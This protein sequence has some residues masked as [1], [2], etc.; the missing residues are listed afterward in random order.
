MSGLHSWLLLADG[1]RYQGFWADF[2]TTFWSAALRM[3]EAMVA[4][5]PFLLAGLLAAGMLRGMVGADRMRAALGV[6]HWSGPLRAWALGILL[7]ICSLGALPVARELRRAG[8]PSGTVLSFV[9]VAPVL[10]PVSI[11]Y[12]MS[13]IVP[14]TLVYF[15]IGTF[16]VSVGIGY[17]WNRLIARKQDATVERIES[18]PRTGLGRL[19]VTGHTTVRGL[20][21]PD[22]VD[23]TLA[24]LAVGLLGAFLPHGVLQ[25]GMTR[26]NALAPLLMGLVAI[27]VYVTPVDVMMHFGVIVKDGFSM[28]AAFSL[29]VLG[30]GANVGV[31]NWIRRDYGGKPLLLFV[32]LL[33]GST[34]VLGFTADRA[35]VHGNSTTADHTH[36]F[37]AFTRLHSVAGKSA[38]M[39]WVLETVADQMELYEVYGICL[40]AGLTV[41]GVVVWALGER[42]S[43]DRFLIDAAEASVAKT[44]AAW[45]PALSAR[46]LVAVTVVGVVV[47]A[48]YGLYIFYPPLDDLFNDMSV[49]RVD[50]YDAVRDRD[51][52]ESR[53]R[54]DQWRNMAA[55]L[56]TSR[57]IR[58]GSVSDEQRKQVDELLYSL[59]TLEGY[60]VRRQYTEAALI[61]KF[62]ENRYLACRGT[63]TGS[64]GKQAATTSAVGR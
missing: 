35:I 16:V 17:L 54:L 23:Y 6:G 30:A 27:P 59:D 24:M 48:G 58:T 25:T 40:L 41:V 33:I 47:L 43:I 13:H 9:L 34:L 61:L 51:E 18:V 45:N 19:A 5:S 28:G 64:G 53:R 32:G 10:N 44:S 38:S 55:K 11:I 31:A 8:V 63:Y 7:P 22:F 36:A 3:C 50:A 57:L 46:Q 12:G 52:A 21:G 20:V 60:V 26:D 14:F 29:I 49:I 42:A 15:T 39:T 62:V 4:A 37:D 2:N 56:P 1:P